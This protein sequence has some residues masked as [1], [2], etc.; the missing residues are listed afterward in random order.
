MRALTLFVWVANLAFAAAL[1]HFFDLGRIVA[2]A[3]GLGWAFGAVL[4]LRAVVLLVDA[5]SWRVLLEA[6]MRPSVSG[7]TLQRWIGES[8]STLLPFAA[9]SGEIA[10]VRIATLLG[11][12]AAPAAGSIVVD[13]A[14]ALISQIFFLVL[15]VGLLGA[16]ASSD[17]ALLV[18][19]TIATGALVVASVVLWSALRAGALGRF[20][21]MLK[22]AVDGHRAQ[23]LAES[24]TSIDSQI[25]LITAR[26]AAVIAAIVW[27]FLGW[28]L[29]AAEVA[30]ILAFLGQP[31][32][33][34][35]ALMLDALTGAAR[36]AFW[37]VP[38]GLGV[39]EGTLLLFGAAIGV[40]QEGMLAVALIKRAREVILSIPGLLAW[41]WIEARTRRRRGDDVRVEALPPE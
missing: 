18:P 20:A 30:L 9:I 25:A 5:H 21:R 6:K 31:I 14:V 13:A 16:V 24:L 4:G 23:W 1:V 15:G 22:G 41:Q 37:F 38:I 34:A 11:L 12:A 2:T 10:R 28:L 7:A 39:Q 8:V 19:V 33:F 35:E 36:T 29:G 3:L 27:R 40:T 26:R 32:S 17:E